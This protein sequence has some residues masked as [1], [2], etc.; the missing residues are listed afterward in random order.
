MNRHPPTVQRLFRGFLMRWFALLLVLGPARV[1]A[2]DAWQNATAGELSATRPA[3]E[4][5]APAEAILW[6][7]DV[8]ESDYPRRRTVTE[9]MRFKIFDPE[10]A[11]K[12]LRLSLPSS[13]IDGTELRDSE[14]SARLTLPNGEVR[15]FGSDAILERTVVRNASSDSVLQ[16]VFGSEGLQ[17]KEKFLAV[18]GILPGSILEFRVRAQEMSPKAATF[19]PLQFESVP[20]RRLEYQQSPPSDRNLYRNNLFVFSPR[21]T[22]IAQDPHSGAILVTATDLPSIYDEPL[23]GSPPY[24]ATTVVSCYTW[25][26]PRTVKV[27]GGS[28]HFEAGQPWAAT[29]SIERWHSEDHIGETQ[30]VR[31]LAAELTRGAASEWEKARRIHD[32][33]QELHARFLRRRRGYRGVLLGYADIVPMDEVIDF[34]KAEPPKLQSSDFL[35]L[36]IGLYSAAGIEA[37]VLMLPDRRSAPFSEKTVADALLPGR[38]AA[39]HFSDG[40]HFSLPNGPQ[41]LAFDTLPWEMTGQ[42]GLLALDDVK[43]HFMPV[44]LSPPE[45]SRIENM[46]AFRLDADGSLSG[47]CKLV[48]RGHDADSIRTVLSGLGNQQQTDNMLRILSRLYSGAGLAVTGLENANDPYQPVEVSYRIRWPGY[49]ALTGDRMIFN[50]LVFRTRQTSPFASAERHNTVY[51]PFLRQ[52]GDRLTMALPLGYK[53]EG[54]AE[55]ISIPGESLSYRVQFAYDPANRLLRAERDFSSAVIAMPVTGYPK[56]KHWYDSVANSDQQSLVLI[57]QADIGAGVPAGSP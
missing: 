24:F 18:G 50:P 15:E 4:A 17:L 56:M 28:R 21:N 48:L 51:F 57:K 5:D 31:T 27:E 49:A 47:E 41:A 36:A 1:A 46:G 32:Y 43:Q 34:E 38:C 35:W 52:E 33:V 3:I 37:D 6:K 25:T 2:K 45:R 26:Q 30:A 22:A 13:S 42:G 10:K 54:G 11:V 7:I 53:L 20:V 29:A 12:I 14:M 55:P 23:S 9:Y 40:W 19:R 44:P 8:D 16:R 39:L